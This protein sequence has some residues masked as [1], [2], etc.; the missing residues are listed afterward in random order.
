MKHQDE[1]T[2]LMRYI[3]TFAANLEQAVI[4][5][6]MNL[7]LGELDAII[8]LRDLCKEISEADRSCAVTGRH[9]RTWL[10]EN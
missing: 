6:D 4:K 2:A 3:N 1:K 5:R 8:A 9:D 7:T 10:T